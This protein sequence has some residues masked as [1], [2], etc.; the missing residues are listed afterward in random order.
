[1]FTDSH[2]HLTEPRLACRLPD[3]LAQAK[4]VG[5]TQF[6]SPATSPDDWHAVLNLAQYDA[7]RVRAL[8]I[9]P[10]FVTSESAGSLQHLATLLQSDTSLWLGEIGL[11]F[12]D[13]TQSHEHRSLQIQIFE[14]QL[15]LSQQYQRPIILHNLKATAQIVSSLQRV[16]H[17]QGG[18]AHAFSGSWEEAQLLLQHDFVI[19]IGTLLLNPHAK[20]VRHLAQHLPLSH[21]L[22]ETDS[23]FGLKNQLNT[24]STLIQIATELAR[25]RRISLNE[26]AHACECNLQRLLA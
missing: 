22:L 12:Y 23:P 3:V 10:W 9:H 21:L 20:K 2:C 16:K 4:A 19:G 25:I 6:I 26:L 15:S 1:M 5:I 17:S 13:K 8:G 18:I 14:M 24:P 11:D 7:V